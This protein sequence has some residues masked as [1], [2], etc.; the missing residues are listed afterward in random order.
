MSARRFLNLVNIWLREGLDET[1]TA[2]LDEQMADPDGWTA[3]K[4]TQ[5]F[6]ELVMAG[7]EIG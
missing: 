2:N 3:R 7:G 6:E 1:G 5:E 4:R